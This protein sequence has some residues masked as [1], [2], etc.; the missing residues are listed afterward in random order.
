ML[1]DLPLIFQLGKKDVNDF[2]LSKKDANDSGH[3][4]DVI[5]KCRV[6]CP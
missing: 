1:G 3:L 6:V 4:H 5:P 2:W